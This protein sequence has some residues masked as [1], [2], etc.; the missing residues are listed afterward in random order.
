MNK[1]GDFLNQT[2]NYQLCQWDGEDRILRTD[3]NADNAKI[4][5]AIADNAAAIAAEAEAR[6]AGDFR[7]KLLDMTTAESQSEIRVN[8]SGLDLS[9]YCWVEL[10]V[11]CPPSVQSFDLRF[12]GVT[13][14]TGWQA[15]DSSAL[16]NLS[17]AG[18]G[19]RD[20]DGGGMLCCRLRSRPGS[21]YTHC[22]T[23]ALGTPN[24]RL[25]HTT[26]G[27]NLNSIG[28]FTLYGGS[29]PLPAGSR[30][31]MYGVRQ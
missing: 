28:Y 8:L 7:V 26:D 6:T 2:N 3:F 17:Y 21:S 18:Q 23:E 10:L 29:N 1:R 19:V 11:E 13:S 16:T 22:V 24:Y 12:D 9:P 27:K 5:A 30:V 14:Y 20:N 15:G 4:D 25:L 31:R